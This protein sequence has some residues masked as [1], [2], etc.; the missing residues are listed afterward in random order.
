[1]KRE[2]SRRHVL[3]AL[4]AAAAASTSLGALAQS[5]AA[6]GEP[7]LIGQSGHL[8][9]PLA[10]SFKGTLAGQQLAIDEFNAKGG[11]GG[12]PVKLVQLDDAYDTKKA[13]DNVHKLIDEHK[14]TALFGLTST[15]IVAATL[16]IVAEKQVPLVGVYTGSPA[17]RARPNPF[18]FTTFA[19]YRDE[20]VQMIRNQKTVAR[21]RIGVVYMNNPLGQLMQPVVEEVAKEQGVTLVAKAMLAGDGSD[22]AAAVQALAAT[23]PQA[24]ILVA[25]GPA[26]VPF[27]KQWHSSGGTPIYTISIANSKQLVD[28]MGED[29]RGLAFTQLVP[30]P[31]A[32]SAP[33]AREFAA[34]MA[35]AGMGVDY[36]H[37]FG[38]INA[39][40]LLE[41]LKRAG[42]TVTPQSLAATLEKMGRVDLGGYAVNYSPANHHGSTF[43]DISII[44]PGGRFIR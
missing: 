11:V 19:S 1:M 41:G 23:K 24:V 34:A 28:A 16:P 35:K 33:L 32:T 27:V 36:D 7:I 21:D 44:G 10:P 29:S 31:W 30:S 12:R 42:K 17:V 5:R 38:Y 15:A 13:V 26:I 37:Y 25:F 22:A 4:G 3:R 8:S 40:V 39:R 9:G 18:F 43:V 6:S 20:V 2:L 14:V